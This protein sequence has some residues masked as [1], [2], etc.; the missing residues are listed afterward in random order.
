MTYFD[1]IILLC[2]TIAALKGFYA[3]MLSH[4]S[5]TLSYIMSANILTL[6]TEIYS[7]FFAYNSIMSNMII[8][9]LMMCV[10]L[11][12]IFHILN[13]FITKQIKNPFLQLLNQIAGLFSG[14]ISM[15]IF[16]LTCLYMMQSC[17]TCASYI[18]SSHLIFAYQKSQKTAVTSKILSMVNFPKL[19]K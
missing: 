16:L 14:V 3:G 18:P 11:P 5:Y 9:V 6:I 2:L 10:L 17:K 4:V 8:F 13:F 1:I 19:S 12:V 7:E 15:C